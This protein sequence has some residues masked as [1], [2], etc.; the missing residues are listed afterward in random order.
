MKVLLPIAVAALCEAAV[1]P[2]LTFEQLVDTSEQIVHGR[3]ERSWVAWDRSRQFLWTHYEVSVRDSIKGG[4]A[5]SIVVSEPGGSLD[6]FT[7]AISGTVQYRIGEEV[8]L[9]LHR[10]PIGYLRA[11]GYQQGKYQVQSQSA[12]VALKTAVRRRM[13]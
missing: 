3:V 4:G 10:T 9:F 6:G 12:A 11:N 7:L 8:V 5:A 2:R 1:V 13:Q